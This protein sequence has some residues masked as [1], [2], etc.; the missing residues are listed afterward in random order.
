MDEAERC[1][2]LVLLREG[3]LLASTTVEGL[4]RRTGEQDLDAA[5]LA[6]TAEVAG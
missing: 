5:L 2:E 3:A 6:L 4:R 1:D